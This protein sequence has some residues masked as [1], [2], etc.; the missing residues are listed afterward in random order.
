[1]PK[2][3]S[4]RGKKKKAEPQQEGAQNKGGTPH[5]PESSDGTSEGACDQSPSTPK[6]SVYS[7]QS[8]HSGDCDEA[9]GGKAAQ[10]SDGHSKPSKKTKMGKEAE[11]DGG[12]KEKVD[13]QQRTRS[14][15]WFNIRKKTSEPSLS[16]NEAQLPRRRYTH[17]EGS[18]G[19][20]TVTN[21]Q[22]TIHEEIAKKTLD[23]QEVS[24]SFEGN[25]F[26]P[27]PYSGA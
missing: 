1:M 26:I 4:S 7:E 21:E 15:S 10:A 22:D 18:Q 3:G 14:T 24:N 25:T 12:E 23:S 8:L 11:Q 5:I 27:K 2:K 6:D 16:P 19:S 20:E 13:G 17:S 9:D